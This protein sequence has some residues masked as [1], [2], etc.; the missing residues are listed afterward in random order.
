MSLS[1]SSRNT[2][3]NAGVNS[4]E[5]ASSSSP[6]RTRTGVPARQDSQDSPEEWELEG[7][8]DDD[9]ESERPDENE[10]TGQGDRGVISTRADDASM[11][12]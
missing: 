12:V 11:I 9:E 4:G 10:I 6:S 3:D 8:F 1:R 5:A 7:Y 2:G